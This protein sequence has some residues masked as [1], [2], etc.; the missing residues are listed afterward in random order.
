MSTDTEDF[1]L[2]Q[3]PQRVEFNRYTVPTRTDS[4]SANVNVSSHVIS[5]HDYESARKE[6]DTY[7]QQ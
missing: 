3:R 6:E 2:R 1:Y 5:L 7:R 4:V